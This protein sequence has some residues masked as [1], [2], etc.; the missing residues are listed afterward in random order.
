MLI[1]LISALCLGAGLATDHEQTKKT[2]EWPISHPEVILSES[3]GPLGVDMRKLAERIRK[4]SINSSG[5]MAISLGLS[6]QMLRDHVSPILVSWGLIQWIN[7][8]EP[9][10]RFEE[11]LSRVLLE[12]PLPA[13][14]FN[15]LPKCPWKC[16]YLEVPKGLWKIYNNQS[17]WHDAIGIYIVQDILANSENYSQVPKDFRGGRII[18]REQSEPA[19]GLWILGIGENKARPG[20]LMDDAVA[21]AGILPGKIIF[22]AKAEDIPGISESINFAMNF[23]ILYNSMDRKVLKFS[24]RSFPQIGK[25]KKIRRLE[26][27]GISHHDYL[28]ISSR[29]TTSPTGKS[30]PMPWEG[31]YHQ[32]WVRGHWQRYWITNVPNGVQVLA[33]KPGKRGDILKQVWKYK[34]MAPAM[35][36]GEAREGPAVKLV[37]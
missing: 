29:Q 22:A 23:L 36:R 18:S 10:L 11:D 31:P 25:I 24:K 12:T 17:G 28:W 6:Q 13:S 20:E 26:R 3:I 27:K 35:R 1:S 15:P 14:E 4:S 2:Q 34:S 5:D 7:S 37:R 19:E 33:E 16:V 21:Y 9:I 30:I 32:T 8:G